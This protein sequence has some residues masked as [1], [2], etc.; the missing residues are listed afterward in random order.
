MSKKF[1]VSDEQDAEVVASV[2]T[3]NIITILEQLKV[4]CMTNEMSLLRT[5]NR[6]DY[7]QKCGQKFEEYGKNFKGPNGESVMEQFG[8]LFNKVIEE[9]EHF[10]V[11]YLKKLLGYKTNVVQGKISYKDSSVNY[12]SKHFDKYYSDMNSKK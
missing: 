6:W 9:H 4:Y 10:D 12:G 11:N 5:S 1:G 8:A 3:S 7:V 2:D